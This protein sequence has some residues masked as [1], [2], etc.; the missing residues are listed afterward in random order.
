MENVTGYRAIATRIVNAQERFIAI[1]ESKGFT[2][3]DAVKAMNTMLKLK[4]AKLDPVSGVIN[5]RHGAFL[6]KEVIQNAVNY[7]C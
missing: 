2:R 7:G 1:L 6:E 5:V 4:V 3:E